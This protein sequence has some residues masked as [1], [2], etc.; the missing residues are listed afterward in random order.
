MLIQFTVPDLVA[1]AILFLGISAIILFLITLILFIGYCLFEMLWKRWDIYF[2]GIY[3][4]IASR[5][6]IAKVC[7]K[8]KQI[9]SDKIFQ[10]VEVVGNDFKSNGKIYKEERPSNEK[11]KE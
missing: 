9:N 3:Y 6:D 7:K 4:A 1:R 5:N 11:K 8:F 2:L 10:I